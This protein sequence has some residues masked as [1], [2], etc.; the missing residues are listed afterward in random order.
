MLHI[1]IYNCNVHFYIYAHIHT[2][3]L[4]W[5]QLASAWGDNISKLP[6][7]MYQQI[8][9]FPACA[10]LKILSALVYI[11][12][13][14][15]RFFFSLYLLETFFKKECLVSEFSKTFVKFLFLFILNVRRHICQNCANGVLLSLFFSSRQLVLFKASG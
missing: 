3:S 4:K 12:K 9:I 14:R 10:C 11:Y 7:I 13:V 8:Y 1:S 6:V 15:S 5:L 2:N